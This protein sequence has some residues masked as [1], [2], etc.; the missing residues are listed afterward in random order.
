MPFGFDNRQTVSD[1][2]ANPPCAYLLLGHDAD[3]EEGYLYCGQ[4]RKVRDGDDLQYSDYVT[5]PMIWCDECGAR[6]VIDHSVVDGPGIDEKKAQVDDPE[7]L[8]GVAKEAYT[9]L[10]AAW[11]AK[12]GNETDNKA[13]AANGDGDEARKTAPGGDKV[14]FLRLPLAK[15]HKVV[16]LYLSDYTSSTPASL[17][18]L[19]EFV[20]WKY[21]DEVAAKF[22]FTPRAKVGGHYADFDD[23]P[24][25]TRYNMG[26]VIDTY[27]ANEAIKA[28]PGI[29]MSHD[30]CYIY[31][32]CV[33]SATGELYDFTYWGD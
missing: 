16:P 11:E 8:E 18:Q 24:V 30:G 20:L 7:A 32:Q 17:A 12:A 1:T 6:S 22:G 28:C 3:L 5:E 9:A 21:S 33:D 4:C 29:D 19:Q 27:D 2:M 14:R 25:A 15:I 23:T 10:L 26:I 31:L 13:D